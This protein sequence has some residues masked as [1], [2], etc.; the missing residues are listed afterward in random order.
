L[1]LWI[2]S[3]SIEARDLTDLIEPGGIFGD[4]FINLIDRFSERI[5]FIQN[6]AVANHQLASCDGP[7][8]WFCFKRIKDFKQRICQGDMIGRQ[9]SF[10]QEQREPGGERSHRTAKFGRIGAKRAWRHA[11]SAPPGSFAV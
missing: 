10:R 6:I 7:G 1:V 5:H 2:Q 3:R 4:F 9:N 11:V 8:R